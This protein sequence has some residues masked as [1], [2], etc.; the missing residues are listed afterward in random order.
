[1]AGCTLSS[2]KP[3]RPSL[4]DALEL[5][6]LKPIALKGYLM[7]LI[8]LVL[9]AA[10]CQVSFA[11]EDLDA[12]LNQEWGHKKVEAPTIEAPKDRYAARLKLLI[13]ARQAA[14]SRCH[15]SRDR[16]CKNYAQEQFRR[17]KRGLDQEFGEIDAA[18]KVETRDTEKKIFDD[19]H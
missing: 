2:S 1:M 9:L 12:E 5:R 10:L 11:D 17:D 3:L 13:G 8:G 15:S 19:G 18:D 14:L 7:R 16:Y 6:R 4:V